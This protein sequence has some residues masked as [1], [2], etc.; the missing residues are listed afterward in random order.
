M[1]VIRDQAGLQ[2]AEHDVAFW[3]RYV[4]AREFDDPAGWELQNLLTIARLM[5]R[6]AP[7]TRRSRAASIF[8]ATSR[9]AMMR[10]GSGMWFV[11]VGID[12]RLCRAGVAVSDTTL[13][14]CFDVHLQWFR[15]KQKEELNGKDNGQGRHP[16]NPSARRMDSGLEDEALKTFLFS[17]TCFTRL[18]IQ[19]S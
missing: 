13:V 3:C 7:G 9:S 2:E 6:S 1:G 4:L 18:T 14:Y 12:L 10:I 19:D 8:A 16:A 11:R 17:L 5:I 15:D